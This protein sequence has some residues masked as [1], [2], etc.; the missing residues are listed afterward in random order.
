MPSTIHKLRG[1]VAE[2]RKKV[3]ESENNESAESET[4]RSMH[5]PTDQHRLFYA[6]IYLGLLLVTMAKYTAMGNVPHDFDGLVC[7]NYDDLLSIWGERVVDEDSDTYWALSVGIT[8][9]YLQEGAAALIRCGKDLEQLQE[10]FG[11]GLDTVQMCT[12][13][14]RAQGLM[15]EVAGILSEGRGVA[16]I[17]LNWR[18]TQSLGTGDQAARTATEHVRV[19]TA[20]LRT[21]FESLLETFAKKRPG[22]PLTVDAICS[23]TKLPHFFSSSLVYFAVATAEIYIGIQALWGDAPF[24]LDGERVD[25]T[26]VIKLAYVVSVRILGPCHPMLDRVRSLYDD[27][28]VVADDHVQE[29][30]R[31]EDFASN[32]LEAT[33]D[34]W[35]K[36]YVPLYFGTNR[37]HPALFQQLTSQGVDEDVSDHNADDDAA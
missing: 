18:G 2:L 22:Q 20:C 11:M 21:E 14:A 8:R 24:L 12:L 3:E 9:Y 29:P 4:V 26:M 37:Q 10:K 16:F 25:T 33:V 7:Q 23:S 1:I 34:N 17:P 31:I 35:L 5:Y 19:A 32:E 6:D 15:H 13:Q 28:V 36:G 27:V 30:R